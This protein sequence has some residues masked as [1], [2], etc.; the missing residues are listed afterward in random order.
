MKLSQIETRSAEPTDP[1]ADIASATR[2]VDELRTAATAFETRQTEALRAANDR[3]AALET[4]LNRPGVQQDQRDEPS[5]EQRAFNNFLRYG[6]TNLT[7]EETRALTVS[8][9]TAGGFITPDNFVG[10]LLRNVVQFSPMRQYARVMNVAGANVRMPKRTGTMTGAWVGETADR[11]GTQPTYGEVELTPFEAA[12]YVDVSNQLLEDSAFNLESELA[13]DAAEEFGRLE[14]A[15]FVSGDGTGKPKGFITD[16]GIGTVISGHASTLG[17]APADKLIDMFY[18][19]APAY[20]ANATWAL[21]STS[22]ASVRKLKDSQGNFLWQPGLQNGEPS[23]LL[24]RPVAELPDM[25]DV[26]AGNL[27]ILLGDFQQGYRIVDRVSLAILRD[28]YTM[29]TKGQT[30]FHMRRRVGGGVVKAE[31]FRA[32]KISAT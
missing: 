20:R 19:L 11:T 6:N 16:A 29:E 24:G 28:P 32:L 31:A 18:A 7:P 22:L 13:F 1:P 5:V 21:N 25:P 9:D 8:T 3:I 14:G 2:A 26:G 17:S 15:A 10:E 12:C 4:R 30:R 23:T 27:P